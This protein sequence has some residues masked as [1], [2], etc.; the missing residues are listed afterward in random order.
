MRFSVWA[1]GQSQ[2]GRGERTGDEDLGQADDLGALGGGVADEPDGLVDAALK[3]EPDAA[4]AAG[5]NKN[6][7]CGI[8]RKRRRQRRRTARLARRRP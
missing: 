5:A 4:T 8:G 2:R 7:R 6:V 1:R 3:V